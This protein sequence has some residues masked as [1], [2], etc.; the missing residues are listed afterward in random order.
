M[1]KV[2]T[3]TKPKQAPTKGGKRVMAGIDLHSDNVVIGILDKDGQ[4][5]GHRKLDCEL[6]PIL[7]FLAPFKARLAQVA[8]ESTFNWYWLV[9]G[10]RAHTIR[11]SWPIRQKMEPYSG[12]KYTDDTQDAFFAAERLRLGD[13]ANGIYI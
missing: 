6:Q 4:R 13:I 3:A 9:D 2:T 8:V 12:L 1:K 7:G 11:W 5:V 10:L